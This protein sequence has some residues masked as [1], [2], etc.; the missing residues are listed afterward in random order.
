[1]YVPNWKK[2]T[3]FKIISEQKYSENLKIVHEFKICS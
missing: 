1:M 2:F 3:Y